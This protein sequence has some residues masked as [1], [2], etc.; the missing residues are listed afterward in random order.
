MRMLE[1]LIGVAVTVILFNL[2]SGFGFAVLA[3]LVWGRM[4][5]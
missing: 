1:G 4:I 2:H 3:G 5:D